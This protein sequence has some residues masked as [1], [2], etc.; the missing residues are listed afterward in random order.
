MGAPLV[1]VAAVAGKQK[2][3]SVFGLEKY[4]FQEG[5]YQRYIELGRRRPSDCKLQSICIELRLIS[6]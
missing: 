6:I 4:F 5:F 3:E 1:V 2:F